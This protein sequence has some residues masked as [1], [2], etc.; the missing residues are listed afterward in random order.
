[1][2]GALSLLLNGGGV[3]QLKTITQELNIALEGREGAAK[4][5]LEQVDPRSCQ[6]DDNKA[7]IVN[8]IEKLN[9]LAL[10]VRKEQPTIDAALEELPC[11]LDSIDKQRGDL[12]KMLQALDE[13]SAVGVKVISESKDADDR[14]PRAARPRCC[15]SS[16]RRATTSPTRST[17]S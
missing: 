2:L 15:R 1:M 14:R 13:L 4:S 6:L 11:A 10:S 7:D 3:A 8:A 16:P 5:V 17:S 12:V 9:R